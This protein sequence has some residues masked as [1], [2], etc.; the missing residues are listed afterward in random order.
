MRAADDDANYNLLELLQ[1]EGNDAGS[2][3]HNA[4]ALVHAHVYI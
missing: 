2:H 3:G 4:A 1:R